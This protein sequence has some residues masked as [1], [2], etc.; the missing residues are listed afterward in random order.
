[1]LKPTKTARNIAWILLAVLIMTIPAGLALA[2]QGGGQPV[3]DRGPLLEQKFE[4]TQVTSN[5]IYVGVEKIPYK[6]TAFT[7]VLSPVG[8][9]RSLAGVR[10][11]FPAVLKYYA[12]Q[13]GEETG[14]LPEVVEIQLL[15]DL[16]Q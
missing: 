12:A 2:Q 8:G 13:G 3:A 11:P 5:V 9:K 6:I 4:I 15:E 7:S 1:M 10:A 14:N 16:P